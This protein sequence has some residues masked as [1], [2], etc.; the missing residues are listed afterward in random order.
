MAPRG[1]NQA[2]S[3]EVDA[4]KPKPKG[5]TRVRRNYAVKELTTR[6]SFIAGYDVGGGGGGK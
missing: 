5:E 2:A 1:K 6:E 3:W 4:D